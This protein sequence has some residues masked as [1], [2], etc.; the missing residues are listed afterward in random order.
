MWPFDLIEWELPEFE[1][2][3]NPILIAMIAVPSLVVA[4]VIWTNPLGANLDNFPLWQRI[5]ITLAMPFVLYFV[6]QHQAN[7]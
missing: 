7:K 4:Y 5:F 3:D 1:L 2:P 6:V